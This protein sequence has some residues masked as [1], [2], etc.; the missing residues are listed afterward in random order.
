MVTLKARLTA[1]TVGMTLL[2]A[3]IAAAGIWSTETMRKASRETATV[4]EALRNHLEGDMMH[5]AL[6]GDVLNAFV[7]AGRFDVTDEQ[8]AAVQQELEEHARQFRLLIAANAAL[9]LDPAIQAALGKVQRPLEDYVRSAEK[10]V[11][12]A[13]MDPSMAESG[14]DGFANSFGRLESAMA[15]VSASI[16][17][18]SAST[19][20]DA[21]QAAQLAHWGMIVCLGL[22]L[23][24]GAAFIGYIVIAVL[25]PF[26]TLTQATVAL[27]AGDLSVAVPGRGRADEIGHL[28]GALEV[29][30]DSLAEA[31]RLAAAEKD[32]AVVR[33]R[34]AQALD[35]LLTM[36]DQD[37]AQALR[38]VGA[39]ATELDSTAQSMAGLAGEA[40]RQAAAAARAAEDATGSVQTVASAAEE[41][42][43]S[44]RDVAG[45]VSRSKQMSERA[46][47]EVRATDAAVGGLSESARRI[48][49]VIGLIQQIAGQT[50]LLALNATIEAARAGEAGKGFAVVAS[51]VK[52]L[53]SQV[54]RATEEIAQQ[55]ASV[56]AATTGAVDAIR[57]I[58]TTIDGMADVSVAIAA[59]MEQQDASTSE[60]SRAASLA[61]AATRKAAAGVTCVTGT[62]GRTGA[63]AE[64]V[65][66]AA[67]GLQEQSD[68]LRARLEQFLAE[69]RV[70]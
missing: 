27:A 34:R 17:G 47:A 50:N 23:V 15:E 30:R 16:E 55:V 8:K 68:A 44:I 67:R 25:R 51:E 49:E 22:S 36:F 2:A 26:G 4:E 66:A 54:A 53:A 43:A 39:A 12:L 41:M 40:N 42:A 37:A 24:L 57:T 62:A 9:P 1:M 3:G 20:A 28:A 61:A 5:D 70:A 31:G 32:G 35:N 52:G 69:A 7:T 56:Q 63:A 48:G 18:V 64:Q 19:H 60:I 10:L 46:V 14:L 21:Q 13:L 38:T 11:E 58:G 65:L 29:F 6:R 45:Q 59:A 33:E